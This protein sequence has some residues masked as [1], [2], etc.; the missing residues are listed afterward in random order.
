MV[1]KFINKFS[2]G[3]NYRMYMQCIKYHS[4]IYYKIINFYKSKYVKELCNLIYGDNVAL[5][6]SRV[7]IKDK[8]SENKVFLHQ[9][10][11]YHLGFP[12]KT[13]LFIPLFDY[14]EKHGVLSFYPGTHQY[15]E[16]DK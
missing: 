14:T 10:Y 13:N 9:D 15:Y 3:Y 7:L 8:Q 2:L 1:I 4:F 6:H 11:C 5:Y 16:N 12:N